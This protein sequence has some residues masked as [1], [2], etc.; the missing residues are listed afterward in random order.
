MPAQME[1]FVLLIVSLGVSINM[2][3]SRVFNRWYTRTLGVRQLLTRGTQE[4]NIVKFLLI[5]QI[6]QIRFC[7]FHV[8]NTLFQWFPNCELPGEPRTITIFHN[9]IFF[10]ILVQF[11]D[12]DILQSILDI[13]FH[14]LICSAIIICVVCMTVLC[15]RLHATGKLVRH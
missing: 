1:S 8:S 4:K 3:L 12:V 11:V 5:K 7:Y 6:T 10:I 14:V 2:P 9:F 15:T 13:W